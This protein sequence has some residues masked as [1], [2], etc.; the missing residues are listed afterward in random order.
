MLSAV[1]PLCS[2]PLANCDAAKKKAKETAA[3]KRRDWINQ[4]MQLTTASLWSASAGL[5]WAQVPNQAVR[6][7][8]DAALLIA[9]AIE[10]AYPV[11][12]FAR[13]RYNALF[14]S[15]NPNRATLNRWTHRRRLTDH[16]A[17]NVTT[18][19][20]DTLYSSAWLDLTHTAAAIEV[21]VIEAGR[22]WSIA[23]MDIFTNNF[24]MIGSRLHGS[25]PLRVWLVGPNWQGA[26]SD[27]P[28]GVQLIRSPSND[29]WA[30]G[31]WLI[32][33]ESEMAQVHA[34]QDAVRLMPV[35]SNVVAD[36]TASAPSSAAP[37]APTPAQLLGV[38]HEMFMRNPMPAAD[39]QALARWHALGLRPAQ[40]SP[41]AQLP[42]AVQQIWTTVLPS[43]L[44][45]FRQPRVGQLID[46]WRYPPEGVGRFGNDYALR[47]HIALTGLGAL[48]AQEAV[49]L[50][51][52]FD[53][54]GVKLQGSKRYRIQI[55]SQGI[56]AQ[57]FW[58]LSMYEVMPDGRMFF[59]ANTI[60]RYAVGD[61]TPNLRRD[62]SGVL[63]LTLQHQAP[64]DPVELANW[65]PTPV[66]DFSLMLRAYVPTTQL[67]A[68]LQRLP[69][70]DL[71]TG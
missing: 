20:N 16:T 51:T 12:E 27:V 60:N 48:E 61:R 23:L 70:V 59:A 29:V 49:Y 8:S 44:A 66:G 28:A 43:Q 71:L 47:A 17:R 35:T 11:Y 36:A 10:Y 37:L 9:Q 41:W 69:R 2:I 57:A 15:A 13:T 7:D 31:R 45:A 50:Q 30:L 14:N 42:E 6:I 1:V 39:A 65:L 21:P 18:P 63:T 25:G 32:N 53:A 46:G 4:A 40:L 5:S 54:T 58:S 19:N 33:A 26:P 3:M 38:A 62:T 64:K 67:M 56:G 22:Y 55:P 52:E 24:A 34:I 68:G